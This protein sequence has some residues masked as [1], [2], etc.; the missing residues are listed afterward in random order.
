MNSHGA[1]QGNAFPS[2]PRGRLGC[3][4]P[5][6]RHTAGVSDQSVFS[7]WCSRRFPASLRERFEGSV[8]PHRVVYAHDAAESNLKPNERDPRLV[9]ECDVAYGQPH[10]DDCLQSTSLKWIQLSTAGYTKYDRDDLRAAL[11]SRGAAMTTASGVY[12]EPC[13]QHALAM[14]MSLARQLPAAQDAQRGSRD[15]PYMELRSKSRLIGPSTSVLIVGYGAIGKRLAELLKPFGAKVQAV[16]RTP[17][18]DEVVPTSSIDVIDQLLPGADHV[19]NV[20]P[21]SPSTMKLFDRARLARCKPG[22]TFYNIGRGDTVDQD[23][24]VDM[25]RTGP[26]S[27]AYLDVTTPEPL[28]PEH[29]LWS[30]PNCLIT[31]HTAGGSDDEAVRQIEHFAANLRRFE[32]GE[33]LRDRIV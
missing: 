25:L 14:M 8:R 17:R 31:P 2:L 33:A 20:L 6:I 12:D 15:W 1:P 7:I 9:S 11:K 23:A 21:A 4:R 27:Y 13:A 32:R 16:R 30:L 18:G 24:L 28:P 22:A 5:V 10:V 26:L 3:S 29:A 19:V